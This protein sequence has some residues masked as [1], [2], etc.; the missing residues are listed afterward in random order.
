MNKLFFDPETSLAMN[1][2]KSQN[3][4]SLRRRSFVSVLSGIQEPIP[5]DQVPL[6]ARII[7]AAYIRSCADENLEELLPIGHD[8]HA[9]RLSPI[10]EYSYSLIQTLLIKRVILVKSSTTYLVHQPGGGEEPIIPIP[11]ASFLPN[12]ADHFGKHVPLKNLAAILD[13][14]LQPTSQ[15][16]VD[17]A[18][19]LWKQLA[20]HEALEYLNF[21][22]TE[23]DLIFNAGGKTISILRQVL[24]KYSTSQSFYFIY[25]AAKNASDFIQ[26]QRVNRQHA[27]NTIPGKIQRLFDRS[28]SEGWKISKYKRNHN[29]CPISALGNVLYDKTLGLSSAGLDVIPGTMDPGS[30]DKDG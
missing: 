10:K 4:D 8:Q 27:A 18:N 29:G 28:I 9:I 6:D 25:S 12:I 26:S 14:H 19:E 22:L 2:T 7:L 23:R 21:V 13:E 15:A 24:S 3:L 20:L 30:F 11:T 17:L 1:L 16:E 5:I